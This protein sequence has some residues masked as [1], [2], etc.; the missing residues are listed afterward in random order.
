[1]INKK[2]SS[3]RAFKGGLKLLGYGI[4]LLVG[5]AC[6]IASHSGSVIFMLFMAFILVSDS[7][8]I[9]ENLYLLGFNVPIWI[10]RYLHIAQHN[11]QEKI[12]NSLGVTGDDED[13]DIK[14]ILHKK[15]DHIDRTN[16]EP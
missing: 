16:P 13:E 2:A 1:M 5:H 4:M 10:I 9:L 6:D 14:N 8:S 12:K 7:I 11:I 15:D 3:K